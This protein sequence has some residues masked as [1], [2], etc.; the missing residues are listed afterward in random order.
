MASAAYAY[1]AAHNVDPDATPW[2]IDLIA[3]SMSGMAVT[4]I[5]W[6]RG[7]IDEEMIETWWSG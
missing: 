5:N 6:I 4:G 3:V 1:M 7:A 2:R